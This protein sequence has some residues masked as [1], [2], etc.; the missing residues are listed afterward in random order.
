MR[1]NSTVELSSVQSYSVAGSKTAVFVY[2][3]PKPKDWIVLG[4]CSLSAMT[5]E[6]S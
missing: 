5:V 4:P 2:S 1:L 3:R 6:L